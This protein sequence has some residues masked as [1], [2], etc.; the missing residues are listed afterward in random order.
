M[1]KSIRNILKWW[2]VPVL[3]LLTFLLVETVSGKPQFVERYYSTGFYPL[4]AKAFSPVSS[5]IPF[6]LSDLFYAALILFVPVMLVLALFRKIRIKKVLLLTINII[7]AA[8]T[9][10]YVLWGFNYFREPFNARFEIPKTEADNEVFLQVFSLLAEQAVSN[11]CIFPEEISL[12]QIDS[13]TEAAYRKNAGFLQIKYPMGRRKPKYITL[14]N[15]FAKA[16]IS[17]YYGPFFN[18]VHINSKLHPLEIP[19]VTAHEK[20][21]QLGITS[22]AEANFY[23]WYVCAHSNSEWLRYSAALYI[24]RY[25]LN[26]GYDIDG[27][28]TVVKEIPQPV[29]NDLN[30]IRQHWLALFDEKV[31]DAAHKA[32]DAYLKTNKIEKGA[33]DYAG[34]V[35][36]V[37]D[38]YAAQNEQK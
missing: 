18:E 22:E 35:A 32:N 13:L 33:K 8:Y 19:V 1:K 9:L 7:A 25:F 10:F 29:R 16:G 5:L 37:M 4:I 34:V 20:A 15:F 36:Y 21:H 11:I 6:S 3:A 31:S 30:A 24:I 12:K 17:G 26:H 38:F 28:G 23:A 2:V 27:F 14:S